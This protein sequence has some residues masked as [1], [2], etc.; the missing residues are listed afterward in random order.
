MK[1][2]KQLVKDKLGLS[3]F[4]TQPIET[5]LR[6]AA[7]WLLQAQQGTTDDGVAHSYDIRAN[8][9]LASYPETTGYVIPT[10]FDYA[11][12][13]NAPIYAEAAR[14]MTEWEC[15]IQLPDGGVRAG[16][17]DA[18]I[19]APTIFNTGQALFGWAKAY[20]ET[21]DE[22]FKTSLN[23][24]ADWLV[25]AQDQDGAWRR[26][27]SPFTTSKLNSYNTRTAF[28]LVRAYE[29]V[30]DTRYLDAA[31]A[32]VEWALSRAKTNG[33]LPHNCLLDN[34]DQTALTHTIAYSIRGILE[35]GVAAGRSDY[36]ERALIMATAVAARQ[37]DDGALNAFY[38]PE[39]KTAMKWSCVTGNSQMAINWLRLAQ[40]T[41]EKSLI[42]NAKKANRF[43]MSIQD[44]TT[45][46]LKVKGA[47]KGSHPINGNYMTYRYPNWAT[48][49]F[50]DGLMLEQQF[51][52][53]KNIG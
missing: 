14:R 31:I 6:A 4:Q 3:V 43:N 46:D 8:K 28:G 38:T 12:H 50:M 19:I 32:N 15:E 41:G 51:D 9:W 16:T 21:N 36:I 26:F 40:L 22:R 7:D 13:Y 29:A 44:L 35:V 10:L 45:S 5:H 20:L 48:K 1:H 33:W 11:R 52:K 27:P 37:R 42:A 17:M 47:M 2:I 49:F 23:R 25:A 18:E 39:W 34:A 30:G 24:A 53:V